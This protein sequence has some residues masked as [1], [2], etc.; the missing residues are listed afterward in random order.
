MVLQDG[1]SALANQ[2]L[3][4][5]SDESDPTELE[6]V[7]GLPKKPVLQENLKIRIE[8]LFLNVK[9]TVFGMDRNRI[10]ISEIKM[11]VV[12]W[13]WTVARLLLG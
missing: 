3:S 6:I 10:D 1:T 4:F 9:N 7:I 2:I 12:R 5:S 13:D 11:E 8:C